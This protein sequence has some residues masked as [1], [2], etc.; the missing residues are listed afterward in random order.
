MGTGRQLSVTGAF[1]FLFTAPQPTKL[2]AHRI[3]D[4]VCTYPEKTAITVHYNN[5]WNHS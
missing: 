2:T 5:G 1:Y 4:R 3:T